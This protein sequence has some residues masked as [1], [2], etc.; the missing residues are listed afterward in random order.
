MDTK[1]KF[2]LGRLHDLKTRKTSAKPLLYDPEDLN[3]HAV[4]LGMTGSGKTTLCI[5]LLEEAALLGIPAIMIDPKGDITNAL[6]HFPQLRPK[7]FEPWINPDEA[8]RAGK[9]VEQMAADDAKKWTEG[10][11]EWD[12]PKARIQALADAAEFAVYTPGSNAGLPV[13]ILASLQAPKLNWAKDKEAIR[14]RISST[15]T[16]ILGLVGFEDIDPVKS[17]EHILLANLF[18]LAWSKGNDL[19]LSDLIMQVQNPPLPK[20]GVFPIDEFF[21]PKARAELALRLNNILAAPSFQTWMEGQS[22]DMEGLLFTKTGKPRHC[23]FVL[24]HLSD[25][26]RMFI[27]TLI[28]SAVETWMRTLGGSNELRAI[29]Y[30]DEIFGYLP[31]VSEPPSKAPMMRLLK[32]ARAFGIAQ[33]LA[34]QNTVDVDYKGLSNIGTWFIGKLQTQRDKDR[35]LDGLEGVA[36][37][38]LNRTEYSRIMSALDKRVFLVHNV[39]EKKPQ[40]FHTRFAMNYLPGPLTRAQIP[41]LNDLAGAKAN[42]SSKQPKQAQKEKGMEDNP[43]SNLS[44]TQPAIPAGVQEVFLPAALSLEAAAEA[45]K[46]DLPANAK[47]VGL[48]YRPGLLAQAQVRFAQRKYNLDNETRVAALVSE[49]SDRGLRWEDYSHEPFDERRLESRPQADASFISLAGAFADSAQLKKLEQE[50]IDWVYRSSEL[51]VWANDALKQ[52]G[53]S[54]LSREQFISQCEKAAE[55]LRETEIARTKQKFEVKLKSLERKLEKEKRELTSDEQEV[56]QRKM[57]EMGTH[58]ENVIGLFGGSRRRL[59]TSLTKRR[60]TANAQSDVEDTKQTISALQSEMQ[61]LSNE[62]QDVVEEIDTRWDQAVQEITQIP[63][64]PARSDVYLSLF[65]IAWLPHHRVDVGGREVE[66][67]AY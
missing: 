63:L 21:A 2:Y 38:G 66:I 56:S 24:S 40:V 6:L 42:P 61:D 59:T 25:A 43:G 36:E 51:Q 31:P 23:V 65:G 48:V 41:A 14:E 47:R 8:R 53:G 1:G 28:Y 7:D 29:V 60:L 50:F 10:L 37:G 64:T 9:S 58:L 12:I 32:Q 44:T 45:T 35:L 13:S 46:R 52:Y 39:H 26:E 57:E 19:E 5:T 20:L 4:V 67:P 18:E 34:T 17:R 11:A 15:T 30:F 22:L 55:T 54:D 33:L 27:V 62:I 3:T 16:A 49:L